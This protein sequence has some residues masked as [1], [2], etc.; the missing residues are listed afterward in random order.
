MSNSATSHWE[1]FARRVLDRE[2]RSGKGG[3]DSKRDAPFRVIEQLRGP[4]GRMVGFGGFRSL[5]SRALAL[6]SAED[7]SLRGLRIAADGS[8]EGLGELAA[9][10][11]RDG[12]ALAE[13]RLLTELLG[14]LVTFI[15]AA[16]T[17][18]LLRETWPEMD[19]PNF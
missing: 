7:P 6:A 5:L 2:T 12:M 4:I 14:L 19:D 11:D 18:P 13:L 10:L 1:E 3:D 17:W 9:K 15:G 16:L 8:L